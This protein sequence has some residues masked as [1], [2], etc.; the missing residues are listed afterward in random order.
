MRAYRQGQQP[1]QTAVRPTN[2]GGVFLEEWERGEGRAGGSYASL[3]GLYGLPERWA[4][5]MPLGDAGPSAAPAISSNQQM[6]YLALPAQLEA[7][8]EQYRWNGVTAAL[9]DAPGASYTYQ[10]DAAYRI[11]L[12]DTLLAAQAATPKPGSIGVIIGD[13]DLLAPG[14]PSD[15]YFS[16]TIMDAGETLTQ[17]EMWSSADSLDS[18]SDGESDSFMLTYITGLLIVTPESCRVITYCSTDG[19]GKALVGDQTFDNLLLPTR[20]GFAVRT[21]RPAPDD[22]GLPASAWFEYLRVR[23]AQQDDVGT[24]VFGQ[25][26]GRNW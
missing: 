10:F 5:R 18:I 13:D 23:L 12:F 9:P 6:L 8:E 20:I 2:G 22:P 3:A 26:G 1:F 19:V 25:T 14:W 7:D 11:G 21:E 15:F 4:H 16:N 17:P 24:V